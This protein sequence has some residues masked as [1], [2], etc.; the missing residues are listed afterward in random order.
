MKSTFR[1]VNEEHHFSKRKRIK[2]DRGFAILNLETLDVLVTYT[3]TV[4]ALGVS[5]V[6]DKNQSY[7]NALFCKPF[8][9]VKSTSNPNKV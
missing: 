4:Q 8:Y 1:Y 2:Y 9:A 7:S 5:N 6:A 3:N